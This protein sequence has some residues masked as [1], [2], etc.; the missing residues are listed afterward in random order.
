MP[1]STFFCNNFY[2]LYFDR[3]FRIESSKSVPKKDDLLN[4]NVIVYTRKR[5]ETRQAKATILPYN[6]LFRKIFQ[7]PLSGNAR[8]PHSIEPRD[9]ET[10]ELVDSFSN[11]PYLP[12]P[13]LLSPPFSTDD[14]YTLAR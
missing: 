12:L 2:I 14:L 13:S 6:R 1:Q 5:N 3:I 8:S 4:N 9:I 10:I 7:F 11:A